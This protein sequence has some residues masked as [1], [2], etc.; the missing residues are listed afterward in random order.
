[1]RWSDFIPSANTVMKVSMSSSVLVSSMLTRIAQEI[2]GAV[3][4]NAVRALLWVLAWDEQ[5][6][7]AEV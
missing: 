7:P 3:S 5:A 2:S 1:M 6:E 4:P